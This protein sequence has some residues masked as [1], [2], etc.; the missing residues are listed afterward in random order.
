MTGA[1]TRAKVA[2]FV[3]FQL[4]YGACIV[5]ALRGFPLMGAALGAA[6][7][8]PNL[9]FVERGRRWAHVGLWLAV[10]ALGTAIDSGLLL[11]RVISFPEMAGVGPAWPGVHWLVPPWICVLWIA[12][13]SMLRSSLSWLRNRP[14]LAVALSA[15][16]GPFSFWSATRLGVTELPRGSWSLVVLAVEYAVLIPILLFVSTET[17]HEAHG[18]SH[19]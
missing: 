16:G 19:C 1:T 8:L 15:V 18:I 10:G 2:N 5:G 13:G 3:L 7:L 17:A 6:L 12:V 14:I 9:L 4:C 11:A